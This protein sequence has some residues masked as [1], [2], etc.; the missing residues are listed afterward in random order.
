MPI[1]MWGSTEDHEISEGKYCA[2]IGS[3]CCFFIVERGFFSTNQSYIMIGIIILSS[4]YS[5]FLHKDK[6]KQAD[7]EK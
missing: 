4:V 5:Y 3:D 2:D 7:A 6:M 1:W